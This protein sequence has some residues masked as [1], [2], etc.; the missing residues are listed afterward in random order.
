V[1]LFWVGVISMGRAWSLY[2]VFRSS[3]WARYTGPSSV[4]ARPKPRCQDQKFWP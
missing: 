4:S 1:K 2:K 3:L